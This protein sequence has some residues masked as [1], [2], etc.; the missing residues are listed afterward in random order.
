LFANRYSLYFSVSVNVAL[1]V[2]APD[3]AVT[4]TVETVGLDEPPPLMPELAAQIVLQTSNR[5]ESGLP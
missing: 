3:V 5:K 1:C 2:S 4:V